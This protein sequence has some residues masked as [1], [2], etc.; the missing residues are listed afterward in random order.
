MYQQTDVPALTR[1]FFPWKGSVDELPSALRKLVGDRTYQFLRSSYGW[2]KHEALT[3][4]GLPIERKLGT[5]RRGFYAES[6][7]IYDFPRNDPDDYVSDFTQ[8]LRIREINA[9]NEMFAHK[10]VLRSFL[11]AMGYPQPETIAFIHDGRILLEPFAGDAPYGTPEAL[12]ARLARE[13][14]DYIVKPEDGAFG[15]QLFLLRAEG[16]ALRCR[17]GTDTEAFDVACF[18]HELR[19][20]DGSSRVTL[21]ERRVE[22]GRFWAALFPGSANTIRAL[23]LWTP[24]EPAPFLARAVQRIGTTDTVPTDNWSGGGISAPIDPVSGA[25]GEGRMHPLKGRRPQARFTHH[26]DTGA[27]IAGAV[28]PDWAGIRATVLR[29]AASV[30]F[31][32]MAGWDVLVRADGVPVLLEANGNSDVNLLQVHGGLLRDPAARRFYQ[33]FDVV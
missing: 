21:I 17:R 32:R 1:R 3:R 9:N 6:A 28:L 29:A 19:A 2:V 18:V 26:P 23:T 13:D 10:I 24:G 4:T 31:N 7:A 5:W 12:A 14:A 25:L 20:R 33:A 15:H 16:G 27:A 11:L 22:Q 8:A 30:P